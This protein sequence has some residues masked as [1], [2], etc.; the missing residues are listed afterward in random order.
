MPLLLILLAITQL[1]LAAPDWESTLDGAVKAVVQIRVS[2]TRSF[3]TEGAS[4]SQ[5][6]GF[7]VDAERGLILTNR[8]IVNPGPV[9]AEAVF[10]NNEEV[11]LEAIYRDPVHDFGFFRFD[12]EDVHFMDVVALPLAP[13]A[14]RVGAEIRVVGND[15]GE[16]LS[17]LAGTIARMDRAAPRYGQG[18][19]NDFNTFYYQ[20]ASG[21]SGGSSG[22]PVLDIEGRVLALNAGGRRQAAASY[23]LP[24]DR[25]VRALEL[26]QRGEPVPRGTIQTTWIHAPY[27]EVERLGLRRETEARVRRAFPEDT[28][29]L[30]VSDTVPGGPA[31]G[32]LQS[33][34]VLVDIDGELVSGFLPLEVALDD[35]V[36]GE[37][38]LGIERGGQ[39]EELT[40]SVQDLHGVTPDAYLEMGGAVFNEL[41]Y[42]VARTYTVPVAGVMVSTPGY[43]LRSAGV[44]DGAIIESVDGVPTPDLRSLEAALS[45]YPDGARVA[46]RYAPV[47]SIRDARVAAV[48]IDRRWFDMQLCT[49]DDRTGRWPCEPSPAPSRTLDL[50]PAQTTFDAEG[51]RAAK[52]LAASLV[53]VDF[54]VPYRTEGVSAS[55]F[56]GA[57][58]VIDAERGLVLVDRDT[59]PVTLGDVHLS[60]AGSVRVP[61]RVLYVH[62]VHNLAVIAYDPALLAGTP[63]RSAALRERE[64]QPGDRLWQ[65]GL[66]RDHRVVSAETTVRSVDPLLLGLPDPPQFRDSNVDVIDITEAIGSVGG[67]LTDRRG[68][69]VATWSSFATQQDGERVAF[70]RGLPARIAA[71]VLEPLSEG[72]EPTWRGLGVELVPISIVQARDQG[73]SDS[74]ARELEAHDPKRRQVLVITRRTAG[75][76]AAELLESGD[77]LLAVGGAPVTR[78]DE[79][80][81]A[82]RAERVSLTVLRDGV[83]RTVDVATVTLDGSGVDRV[84]SWAGLVLHQPHLELAAQRGLAPEGVYI[85]WF[86]YGS[87]AARYGLRP[88]RR[89]LEVDG[90]PTPDL[91]SFLTAVAGKSDRDS[92]RLKTVSLDERVRVYTLKLDLGYWPTREFRYEEGEWA[93]VAP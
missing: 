71:E 91:D 16:K 26:I 40:L 51:P 2:T 76:P 28:G 57:G 30:V 4:T 49:R 43:M 3:D 69:V 68:R 35:A 70:F 92:V 17:I 27:N 46:L 83:E 21:T 11:A 74:R 18:R 55:N 29:M 84:V 39:R 32:A 47:H 80:E 8:H 60:F 14:A 15:A 42:Q 41:S 85:S 10:I 66:S 31:D 93:R 20:A 22:S 72:R 23:Y 59:V 62:P 77:L 38:V 9:V 12:P 89:I 82:G 56:A 48:T 50:E 75:T 45:A 73:L 61:G 24:L 58:L 81:E 36:G 52:A 67:A 90:V 87:P 44:P 37:V 5:G 19:F 88:T 65:V 63:V 33:G 25:V 79:V 6:T 86:W 53:M 13:E 7:V 34:D 78:A 64:V 1:A 54:D